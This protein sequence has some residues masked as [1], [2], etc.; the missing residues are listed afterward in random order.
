MLFI[1]SLI[2]IVIGLLFILKKKKLIG[3]MFFL[4]AIMLA[5]VGAVAIVLYPHLWPF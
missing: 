2:F 4:L 1:Y 3:G 5:V